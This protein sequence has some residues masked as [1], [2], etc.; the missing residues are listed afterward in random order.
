MDLSIYKLNFVKKYG[1]IIENFKEVI[2]INTIDASFLKTNI[3]KIAGYDLAENNVFGSSYIVC[4]NGSTIYKNH[5]GC[6]DDNTM[7]RLASMTKPI[8]AFATLI[9]IDRGMLALE[10]KV[11]D[12]LPEFK[13]IHVITP[14]GEDLG[15]SKI[16]ITIKHLLTHTSGFGGTKVVNMSD[17]DITSIKNTVKCFAKAGLD[18]EPFS[19]EAYSAFAAHDALALIIERLTGKDYE[20]FLQEEIFSPC[21]MTNTTFVPSEEQWSRMMTMHNKKDGKSCV[22]QTVGGCVFENFPATHK[23]AGAGLTSTLTDYSLF[24]QMLLNKGKINGIQIISKDTFDLMPQPHA[25]FNIMFGHEQW[26]LSVRVVTDNNYRYLPVGSYGWS[27]AYGTHFWIDPV[28]NI[29]AV[30]M[31]N[32]LFDGGAGNLSAQ[33]FEKAVFAAIQKQEVIL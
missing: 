31:K 22:G 23:L 32:S 5:F 12:Y 9:L 4:Q 7:F 30:F 11:E 20:D 13:D 14:E 28:N 26:G 25:P 24:A 17:E 27:G 8:T 21:G 1:I 2:V 18:F 16:A 10:D 33:R 6:C 19:K 29:T 3:E 15:V